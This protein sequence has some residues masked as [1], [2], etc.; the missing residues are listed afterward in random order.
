MQTSTILV[1]DPDG[2][3]MPRVSAAARPF[4]SRIMWADTMEEGTRLLAEARPDLVLASDAVPGLSDPRKLLD[5]ISR[6]KLA[7]QL[8]VLSSDP[9]FDRSM[10]LVSDGVFVVLRKPADESRLRAVIRRVLDGLKLMATLVGRN[11][12]DSERELEIYKRLA[13]TQELEPL[14]A[15]VRE[16]GDRLAYGVRTSLALAGE[17]ARALASGAT[18]SEGPGSPDRTDRLEAD[19]EDGMFA[20]DSGPDP[21]PPSRDCAAIS[22]ELSFRGTALGTLTLSFPDLAPEAAIEAPDGLD[23]LAWAASLHLYRARQYHEAV[24]LASHDPLTSLLNRRAFMEC[25]D[26]EFAKAGRHNTPLSLIML[27]IDHF[28]S[29]NDTFGHQT[30]DRILRWVAQTMAGTVRT[31]DIVG[32]IGGEEFAVLLPWTDQEQARNLAE[33]VRAALASSR[34]PTKSSLLR[35]TVSQGISTVDHFLINSPED[36]I[37]W[38]DQAMYLAKR[39]GRDTVRAA[40]DL[41]PESNP[42]EHRYVF[43]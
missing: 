33:R 38:S 23:E 12:T 26:R 13:R 27:D 4:G 32:R 19:S 41:R 21:D 5:D 36:L 22:R 25:L 6:L 39:E 10:E 40:S 9:G 43:Q 1:I 7:A 30:G 2:S 28:K 15:A 42:E 14:V 20:F 24:R 11:R 3:E 18:P 16:A 8:V 31:G 35:P 34:L 17:L 37:Y 29:V